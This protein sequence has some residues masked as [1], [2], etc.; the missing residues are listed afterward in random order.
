MRSVPRSSP[1]PTWEEADASSGGWRTKF[2]DSET[3]RTSHPRAN[4]LHPNP[5]PTW[6]EGT[7]HGCRACPE[8]SRRRSPLPKEVW[9]PRRVPLQ[10]LSSWLLRFSRPVPV[11]SR[12]SISF[13]IRSGFSTD[14]RGATAIGSRF[15]CREYRRS[16]SP[17][18]RLRCARFF[19]A[20]ATCFM[21]ARPIVRSGR[22][23][24]SGRRCSSTALS[25]CVSAGCCCRHFMARGWPR[26]PLRCARRPTMRSR[27]G[28]L[29]NSSRFIRRCA[30]SLSKRS[31]A[32]FSDSRTTL[33]APNCARH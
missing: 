32:R 1:P 2:R 13:A 30:R 8:R 4:V 23:W 21:Q 19:W 22:S 15:G 29:G 16:F 6:T 10:S 31:S 25:I 20:T 33:P 27:R 3:S 24:E 28:R 18:T 7:Q 17:A 14:V 5:P 12:R 9:N 26:T 11:S